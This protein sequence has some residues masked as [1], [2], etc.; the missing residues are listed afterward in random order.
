EGIEIISDLGQKRL[1]DLEADS[2]AQALDIF[3]GE[4]SHTVPSRLLSLQ[5]LD[6]HVIGGTHEGDSDAGADGAWLHRKFG[7][8]LFELRCGL[9]HVVDPQSKMVQTE[10]R[11]D[12]SLC[13]VGVGWDAG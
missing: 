13:D 8:A 3:L 10:M 4:I 12:R 7:A 6:P 5:Q 1:F 2:A 9:V 11:V